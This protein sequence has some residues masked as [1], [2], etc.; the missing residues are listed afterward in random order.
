[1]GQFAYSIRDFDLIRK[2]FVIFRVVDN[3][4][5]DRI[6]GVQGADSTVSVDAQ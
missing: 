2:R 1:M 4:A 6:I 3:L 5:T